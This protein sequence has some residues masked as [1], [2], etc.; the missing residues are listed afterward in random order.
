[1]WTNNSM[2]G[3]SD[4]TTKVKCYTCSVFLWLSQLTVN[5]Y[6]DFFLPK[7]SDVAAV[8]NNL[9][10]LLVEFSQT[11]SLHLSLSLRLFQS[12]SVIDIQPKCPR[13]QMLLC[14]IF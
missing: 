1:M 11:T 7:T 3:T 5:S 12:T 6:T 4:Q 13:S 14:W 9:V 8:K 2:C 10:V